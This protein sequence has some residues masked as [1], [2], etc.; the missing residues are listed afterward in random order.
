[1]KFTI[2]LWQI[3]IPYFQFMHTEEEESSWVPDAVA[4]P[5]PTARAKRVSSVLM[6]WVLLMRRI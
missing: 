6:H 4:F 5:V 1:M 3:F 2:F